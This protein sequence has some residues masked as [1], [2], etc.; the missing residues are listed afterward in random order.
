MFHYKL[1]DGIGMVARCLKCTLILD[2]NKNERLLSE[3]NTMQKVITAFCSLSFGI[4]L[5]CRL[6]FRRQAKG[7]TDRER[8]LLAFQISGEITGGRFPVSKELALEMAALMA[9]VS[10][11]PLVVVEVKVHLYH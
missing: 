4:F 8:L 5:Q 7:D 10:S 11:Q 1:M 6:Y 3:Q 2:S 9:Q